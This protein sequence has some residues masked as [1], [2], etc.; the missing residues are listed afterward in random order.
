MSLEGYRCQGGPMD[1][2]LLAHPGTTYHVTRWGDAPSLAQVFDP[3][4]SITM[5]PI[6]TAEYRL[7]RVGTEHFAWVFQ[8]W[9]A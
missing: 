9:P 4:S 1:G 2:Q 7:Q 8:G 5:R 3:N 6:E